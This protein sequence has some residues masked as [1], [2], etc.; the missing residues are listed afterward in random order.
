MQQTIKINLA[1]QEGTNIQL[2]VLPLSTIGDIKNQYET[3]TGVKKENQHIVP[4]NRKEGDT[5]PKEYSDDQTLAYY[6]IRDGEALF[7]SNQCRLQG[8]VRFKYGS[9]NFEATV[10]HKHFHSTGALVKYIKDETNLDCTQINGHDVLILDENPDDLSPRYDIPGVHFHN[11]DVVV[12]LKVSGQIDLKYN[13]WKISEAN[14]Q[15]TYSKVTKIVAPVVVGALCGTASFFASQYF[16][17]VYHSVA[18]SIAA[19]VLVS[20][21]ANLVLNCTQMSR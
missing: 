17:N 4:L 7:V 3:L 18:I 16:N 5:H 8:L 10:S 9:L 11:V 14:L 1:I 13:K 20:I 12:D 21:A 15:N 19:S 2:D 6:N